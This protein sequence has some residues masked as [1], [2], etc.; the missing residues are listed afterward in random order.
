M[1]SYVANADCRYPPDPDLRF[2]KYNFIV[3]CQPFLL[4][5]KNAINPYFLL[6][7][8][9]YWVNISVNK[10]KGRGYERIRL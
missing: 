2:Y 6:T 8:Y 1:Q 7:Y 9:E 3:P 5:Q 10:R 4:Y